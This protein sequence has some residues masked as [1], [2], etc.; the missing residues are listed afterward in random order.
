MDSKELAE[1]L[2]GNQAALQSLM[3]SQ[4]GQALMR[5][6][7]E[8]DGGAALQKAATSASRGD[9]RDMVRMVTELMKSPEGAALIRRIGDSIPK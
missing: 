1:K 6:L 5:K 4:D 2:K 9:T 7:T 3:R 8:N